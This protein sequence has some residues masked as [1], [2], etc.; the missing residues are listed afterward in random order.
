METSFP[1]N[2]PLRYIPVKKATIHDKIFKSLVTTFNSLKGL[3]W[4]EIH[5]PLFHPRKLYVVDRNIS[6][7]E[8]TI[9]TLE[10]SSKTDRDLAYTAILEDKTTFFIDVF[11]T[12]VS[13][14][15]IE[16]REFLE[17][18]HHLDKKKTPRK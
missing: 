10:F 1:L 7:S 13:D 3:Y 9:I 11:E 18:I 14:I 12:I 16:K 15:E 17:A 2:I 4:I 5:K 6:P 8:N